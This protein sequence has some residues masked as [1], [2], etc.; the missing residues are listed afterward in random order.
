LRTTNPDFL[1]RR[2]RE[3]VIAS[4]LV[5]RF[6]EV[7]VPPFEPVEREGPVL[8]LYGQVSLVLDEVANLPEDTTAEQ[9]EPLQRRVES[10]DLPTFVAQEAEEAR[11]ADRLVLEQAGLILQEIVNL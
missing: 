2:V 3:Q 6:Q 8:R 7:I 9:L 10:L 11:G 4:D 1:A 5:P